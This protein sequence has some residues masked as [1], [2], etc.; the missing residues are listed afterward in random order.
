MR[1]GAFDFGHYVPYFALVLFVSLFLFLYIFH[2]FGEQQVS[3][4]QRYLHL[5]DVFVTDTLLDCFSDKHSFDI[6]RFTDETLAS[7]TSRNVRVTLENLETSERKVL[8][9]RQLQPRFISREY[10]AFSH[11]GGVLTIELD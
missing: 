9:N 4:Y 3:T 2:L 1:K 11:H 5:K 6:T 7:C 10:V 8:G